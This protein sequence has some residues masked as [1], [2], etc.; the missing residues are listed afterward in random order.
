MT[1]RL[2]LMIEA[3]R[4][5]LLP[6]E[7]KVL[8]DEAIKRG[9]TTAPVQEKPAAVSVG[10]QLREIPRQVGL[11]ARYGIEGVGD[12]V[13]IGSEPIRV[14]M[15]RGLDVV[16]L[17]RITGSSRDMAGKIA[18]LM[19]LPSPETANERVVGDVARL[20]AP[21]GA[22]AGGSQKLSS[23]V[24]SPVAKEVLTQLGSRA[25]QQVA[26]AGGAGAAGG[27]VREAGGSPGE[28]FAA[29]LVGGLAAGGAASLATK[30]YDG[31]SQAVKNILTPKSSQQQ[32]NVVLN[33]ILEQ[34]GINT[35]QVAGSVRAELTREV[36][37]ALDTGREI[38]PDVVRRIADYGVVG[39]T[40]TRGS[41]T[42]DP[43]LITRE[44]N[45][46][47]AGANSAD[48]RLQELAR[49]R[50]TNNKQ[51]ITKLNEMG[52]NTP[53]ANSVV[54]GERVTGAIQA[55]DAA[56]KATEKALY[57]KARDASGRAIELDREGFINDAYN[58]L[59]EANKTPFLPDN[60][61]S[62]LEEIRT[63]TMKMPDGS[64]R[65]VPF[66]V[67][68]IDNLKTIL[69]TAS[70]SSQDGNVRNAIAQVR[71]ALEATQPKAAGR[72][73]GGNQIVD[74]AGLVAAQSLAD[75]AST[76]AMSAFD[77]ARRFA[78]A[79]R[80]WQ[81]SAE[82][83]K[84][85]LNEVPPDRFVQDFIISKGNKA[86]TAE[87]EKMLFTVRRDPEAMQALKQNVVGFLKNKALSG[88]AD[89]VGNFSASA[90]NKALNEIGDMKLR[91][92]FNKEEIAQ[93]KAIGRVA[94]YETAQPR[95]SA[96]NNS[97]TTGAAVGILE[98]IA[99][100]PLVAK[101]PFG[102]AALRTPARNAV[103]QVTVENAL[104]PYGAASRLVA[105][106]RPGRIAD[107]MVGPGLLLA[108]PSAQ[109]RKDKDRR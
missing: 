30:A 81:E 104:N 36:K 59:G 50:N 61:R 47:K 58:R 57:A 12:V 94:S 74:P 109:G 108:A 11:T 53:N 49:V 52:A 54:A 62:M 51:L 63:G 90:F 72:V 41:V 19:N 84:A 100:S 23:L 93:L 38:N 32:I 79:R 26:A 20:M 17:P 33:Q 42:L 55:R 67:D 46:A 3:D 1:D 70:R 22:I 86:A 16:G 107:L 10:E 27:A 103:T 34:N 77:K 31:I 65:P 8:L 97:N 98:R 28:Q 43:V 48:P 78:A 5:G 4:R 89:E 25:G 37:S 44:Q 68:V 85:A 21:A 95:G 9:L 83:V 99:N 2:Q 76:A 29:S 75:D 18:D 69:A 73:V 88:N 106:Q 64:E 96:V 24:K 13:G 91:L 14:L 7:K 87:V 6:P 80:N 35:A 15:N 56:A 105:P 66:N 101:L 71:G 60:I 45:L 40:P 102:D 92:F 82:G 39:A